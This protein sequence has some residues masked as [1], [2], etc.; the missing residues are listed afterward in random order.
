[1]IAFLIFYCS[2]QHTTV[3]A[4]HGRHGATCTA[5]PDKEGRTGQEVAN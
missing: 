2:V 3:T 1:M 5:L 4:L